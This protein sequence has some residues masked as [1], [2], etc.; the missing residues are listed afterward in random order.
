MT[1]L[2]ACSSA[3]SFGDAKVPYPAVMF[4]IVIP[5]HKVA[6]RVAENKINR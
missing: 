6:E 4:E 1:L 2:V 5:V 3:A